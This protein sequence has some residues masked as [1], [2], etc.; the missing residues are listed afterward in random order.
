[1]LLCDIFTITPCFILTTRV[2]IQT[3][4]MTNFMCSERCAQ[5]DRIIPSYSMI[6]QWQHSDFLNLCAEKQVDQCV[7]RVAI[8][9]I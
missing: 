6:D 2:T 9:A 8:Y 1:M 4:N 5:M 7:Y 3:R